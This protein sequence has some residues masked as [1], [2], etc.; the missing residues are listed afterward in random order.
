MAE[1]EIEISA[2]VKRINQSLD[3]LKKTAESKGTAVGAGFTAGLTA[4]L[5]TAGIKAV[6]QI[7]GLLGNAFTKSIDEAA[8]AGKALQLFNSSLAAAG[9]FSE[10]A[11]KRFQEYASSLQK[12]TGVSDDVI[13]SNAALLASFGKLSGEGLER[14][15]QAAVNLAATGRTSLEGAFEAITK[16]S[17]GN[18]AA[19]SRLGIVIDDSVPKSERFAAAL[20]QIESR[21]GGLAGAQVNTFS[22]A[23]NLLSVSF[24]DILENFGKLVT[25]SP[26]VIGLIKQVGLAFSDFAT[27]LEG[28]SGKDV[29]GD[30]IKDLLSL[31][32]TVITYVVAPFELLFNLLDL[33]FKSVVFT[34]QLFITA[35]AKIPLLLT[36]ITG[37]VI[38]FAG[39]VGKIVGFFDKDLGK[40]IQAGFQDVGGG[41]SNTATALSETLSETLSQKGAE[42][43]KSFS[44][45]LDFSVSS[46]LSNTLSKV[47]VMAEGVSTT[48][49]TTVQN[50]SQQIQVSMQELVDQLPTTAAVISA[51]YSS[52]FLDFSLKGQAAIDALQA[53]TNEFRNSVNGAFKT[54]ATGFA[55]SFAQIGSA[56]VKGQNLFQAFGKAILG[57]FGQLAVNTGTA[58]FL[59]GLGTFNPGQVAAGL[60]LIT[61]GG[62]LQ[63]LAGGAAE[64]GTGVGG[65]ASGGGSIPTQAGV[66]SG[67]GATQTEFNPA[68]LGTQ[69]AVNVQGNIL[70]TRESALEIVSAMQTYFDTN[71]NTVVGAT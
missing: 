64:G 27:S 46:G 18:T 41:I 10:Q 28:L 6:S 24:N 65:S 66:A 58:I 21:L 68:Q 45:T 67:V 69:V 62:V 1:I 71:G 61:L 12:A 50:A 4:A 19:L 40:A 3:E 22:G 44:E 48:V 13:I 38:S 15:T 51:G 16:A 5:T 29:V 55:Q 53:R 32:Q 42:V 47:Q 37:E 63:A 39:N 11:S 25:Q 59:M 17:T 70:N 52:L 30:L 14:A 26:V 9:N 36:E 34:I 20:S 33:G 56:L 7:G 43:G 60:A 49:T 54:F 35:I 57:V 31:G 2:D 8:Q 23:L